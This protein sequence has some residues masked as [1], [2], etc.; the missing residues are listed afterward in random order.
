M[1]VQA[2]RYTIPLL[3]SAPTT[4]A[5]QGVVRILNGTDEPGEIRIY[6]IS[7][8]GTRTGPATI[9]L[10]AS[11]AVQFSAA[12]LQS[13]NATLG[14]TG[15]IGT[16]VG[17]AR[18]E[19]ET[20]IAIVPLT[21]VRAADGTL[22]A[23]HD[24]VR[25]ASVVGS[26]GHTYDVPTFNP[27]SEVTQVSRLRLI[28]PGDAAAAVTISGRDDSGAA[29][30]GGDVTL[31][32]AAGGS[33]TLTAQQLEAGDTALTGRLGAGTGQWRLT[34][35]S[36]QPLQA[37]N[38]VASSAGYWN[39]LS[40]T[41]APGGAPADLESLNERFVGNAVVF[42]TGS[43]RI[44]LDAQTGERFTET[45]EMDGVSSTSMGSYGYARIGADSGRLTLTYD[46]GDVCAVN[47]Y[48]STR[49]AGWFASHCTGSDE[50]A[51][52][53]RLGGNWS[54]GEDEDDG[55]EVTETAYEVDDVLPGVATSGSFNPAALSG[56]SVATTDTGTTIALNNGGYFELSNGTRYTCTSA[57]GCAAANGTVT[58]G[59]ITGRVAGTGEVDRFPSFRGADA[60]GDRTYTVGTAI[61]TLTLPE[62]SGG[63]GTLTYSL[64]PNVPGLTFNAT[65]RQ[66][67]GT[68][69]TVGTYSM[70]YTVTDEDG[71]TDSLGVTIAVSDGTTGTGSLGVC[72]VG[73]L[74]RMGQSCTYPGTDDAFSVNEG[75]RGLFL[76]RSAG[77]RIGITNETIN[78]RVYDFEASH[79][80]DGMWR[81]D[82][83]PIEGSGFRF[84][85]QN[86]ITI[87]AN[88]ANSVHASD[89]DGDGDADVLSA[90]NGDDKIAWYENLGGGA[91]SEQRVISTEAD[92]A[93]SVHASDLDSDGDA[94]VLSASRED[95][96]IA[97]YENLGGGAFSEQRVISTEADDA[98][99]VHASDL[100]GDGDAD[101]LSA[102]SGD[103]K[104]AWYENLGGGAFS[105]QRVISTEADDAYSVHASDLDGDGDADVLSASSGDDK[106]AWY[107]NLGNGAF[108]E[109]RVIST[110]AD[111]AYSVHASDLDGDGDADV[112]SASSGDDKIAWYENLGSG[113][114]SEQRVISTAADGAYSVHASDLDGDGDA[115]VLS[116]SFGD[117]KI[118]WYEN[119]GSGAFSEQ[120]VISTAADGAYSVHASD[121]DGDG[122]ADVLSASFGDG[123]I[124]WYENLG[125]GGGI[126]IPDMALRRALEAALGKVQGETITADEMAGLRRLDA[127]SAG[128]VDLNGLEHA[129]N[130]VQLDLS[131]NAIGDISA[132]AELTRLQ[133]ID[134]SGNN[135]VNLSALAGLTALLEFRLDDN[136]IEDI[137]PLIENSGLDDDV[138]VSLSGNPLSEESLDAHVSALRARGVR[139]GP[140]GTS[141]SEQRDISTGADFALSVHASDLDGD[142]DADV[143]SAS[144]EDDKIAWYENLGGGSFSEQRVISTAADGAYS[145]HASDLD[146]DGDADVLSASTEDDKIA[147]YEN[148]GGGA[149][150]E[151][152]VTSTAADGAL[153]VHASDLDGD[154][155]ADVLSASIWDHKIAW[156]ENLGGGAFSGQRVISTAAEYARSVHASD[157]DGD[158]DADVLSASSGDHKIAWYENL[159]GGAFSEQRVISTAADGARSVHASDLDGDG[160]ADVLSASTGDH[161]IAWY[162]NLGGGAFSE[163]RVISTAAKHAYSVHASDLDGDGD[164]DVL[165][166]ST[167]DDKI[168][169]YENL[170]GGAFSDQRVIS[171]AAD[172]AYSVH[173]SDLDGD[174]DADVLS[175]SA[176]DDKIAWYENLG[177]GGG[178]HIPDIALRRAI[179]AALGK[180]QGETITADEMAG[181]R[182]L[183]AV[184]A[185]II[186]DL[187][188][189]EYAVNLVQLDL[190]GNAIGDISA[191]A[192]LTRLQVIDLSGNNIVNLSALAGL[193]ALLEFRLDDNAIEDISPL[194]ENSGLDDDVL[195]SLSGNPL[196][197]ESLDAHVSALRARGVRFGPA[198][199]SFSEQ[200]D[201]STGADFALSVHASDLDGDGDADVLSASSEDDKIAWYENLGGG[202]FSEQRVISTAGDGA[203]S[204]HASDLDG[205]GDADVL[206]ASTEDDKI[207]W[208]ENFGGG[209]FSEQRVISTATDF[210]LSVHASDLDGDGDA[211]VLSASIWDHKIAWYE[212]LGGGAFSG[213]RVIS[214]AADGAY[215]VHAS[216]LDGDG[217]ADVLSASSG[218]DKIAWYENLGGGSFSEQR[219][220]STAA[221]SARSVYASDLDGDGDADVLSASFGDNKIAWYEN[222][223]GGSF[224]EQRVISTAADLARSVHASDLDGDGD[225]DVLSASIG[226]DKIA[227]YENLGGSFSE[228][229]VISTAADG[230]H[231]VHASD[232]DGD[233]DADVLSASYGDD[234]IAWY[235]NLG[236]GGNLLVDEFPD[237][238]LVHLFNDNVIVMRVNEDVATTDILGALATYAAHIYQWFEDEFDYL[239]FFSNL[240]RNDVSAFGYAGRYF[241]VM[242]D[243]AGIGQSEFYLSRYG[244][245]GRLRGVI[246]FP[247][248]GYLANGPS[249]HELQHAWSNYT[250]PTASPGHWGFSSADGQLG[251]FDMAD[252]VD[253]GEGRWTA[254]R[255]GTFAAGGNVVPYSL[256]ELYF[257]GLATPEEVPDLW[258][259][260]DGEWLRDENGNPVVADNGYNVFASAN[261]RTYSIADIVAEHGERRPA[262]AEVRRDQRAAVILLTDFVRLSDVPTLGLLSDQATAFALQG[263]DGNNNHYNY[264]E[265]TL[266]RGTLTLDGLSGLL[267][268]EPAAPANLPASFGVAPPPRMTT[269]AELCGSLE[270]MALNGDGI[271]VAAETGATGAIPYCTGSVR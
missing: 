8:A 124:A 16:D 45:T 39:N 212:N 81:I 186:A 231:S 7:D 67:T 233:G 26:G 14:L 162:E 60:P 15:G 93:N 9:T 29:A 82:R 20:D 230:A 115:D 223:G 90:S 61:D 254:G 85:G 19:I 101:V 13:G 228:Q 181:L 252:L 46:D 139:F 146:G 53:T 83:I 209:S 220:I 248:P 219:V 108:S 23:M 225:A 271:P 34:V 92:D 193:P 244:S 270:P 21:F 268:N 48:F 123:K 154:G 74:V 72:Q 104:I 112:L 180:V 69:S 17:D 137:S 12:D 175:A 235:E 208:H 136:A 156:Y 263:D 64:S 182:R 119:L 153:S 116:A 167:G 185:G 27:A 52:G 251:G 236:A 25:A 178:I 41:A 203:Y 43:R 36:D 120:R 125:A 256:I 239:L 172:G 148:F 267:K 188:G 122:D 243:T 257:A 143:L 217:D 65:T 205:D 222:L 99:S 109:Q 35:S 68:P 152:R 195:V 77:I 63:N 261:P 89:L 269:I 227:W 202:S 44:T 184:S 226:D 157:L 234:K 262:G 105:E 201:I 126:H 59:S 215:S 129:V 97:W 66:L 171:T 84:S 135:I 141:F 128:I 58:A 198:G 164:A 190:S 107:E 255:F 187:N 54:A 258:V 245:A 91:F 71:D 10:N 224:S 40:T 5:P 127:V 241:S 113:A 260:R 30:T 232:L 38:I 110:E 145:V 31:T 144:S 42:A 246:H 207:A 3:V 170:G 96:K 200:R 111:G 133:V 134:L 118:A 57:G 55:G 4:G 132:L 173:A 253:L 79:Q 121:L 204:V 197:E 75:G 18:L 6:A 179:E 140:A 240:A 214:T 88:G 131:G 218:D 51:E 102:S 194:I 149:F 266:G 49:T 216:D 166:A 142:G 1:A 237:S 238:P 73:M 259:A 155:D 196:S 158:G 100:D 264:Y 151:Q 62:A 169:W 210:A 192:G 242:N 70:T 174:G 247:R 87:D 229:R 32:L 33:Q 150:S 76:G 249:L 250:V 213:Q 106:I 86:V 189:L 191:L 78:G 163:Q 168:A 94:D 117:G 176:F 47:L 183:V 2:E 56:G 177:A 28:N 103:D 211:D 161:K 160:D 50:P 130:L 37:V 95:D 165:S 265:A 11:A 206:S 159:G 199:T 147:W 98:Y 138:L 80:G 114:F 22:S 24:T 221:T